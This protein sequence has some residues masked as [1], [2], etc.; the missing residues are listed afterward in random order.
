MSRKNS[1]LD[2][3]PGPADSLR[4]VCVDMEALHAASPP[5]PSRVGGRFFQVS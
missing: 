3:E 1:V 4:V 5:G 2:A